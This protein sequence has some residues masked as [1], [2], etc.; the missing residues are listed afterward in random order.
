LD[1]SSMNYRD[2][3]SR[4]ERSLFRLSH[5]FWIKFRPMHWL[6]FRGLDEKVTTMYWYQWIVCR[7]KIIFLYLWIP[8]NH[9]LWQ[10]YSPG[11]APCK[12]EIL[13]CVKH[14]CINYLAENW[15]YFMV[16]VG[17]SLTAIDH[18]SWDFERLTAVLNYNMHF[19]QLRRLLLT[20]IDTFGQ[21]FEAIPFIL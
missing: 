2:M 4:K 6:M 3:N 11:W 18:F 21:L 19:L 8:A 20:T 10:C 12:S 7:I 16:Q 13:P 17:E 14:R 15:Q 9:S 5:K 1:L